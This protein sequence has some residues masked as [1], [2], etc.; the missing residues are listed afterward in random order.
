M[1]KFLEGLGISEVSAKNEDNMF[2]ID[3][4]EPEIE[5]KVEPDEKFK[6]SKKFKLNFQGQT[7]EFTA[8]E[9]L[10]L[11]EKGLEALSRKQVEQSSTPEEEKRTLDII[12]FMEDYPNVKVQDIPDEVWT[13]VKNGRTLNS[14]YALWENR[15]LKSQADA[16]QKSNEVS[17]R[18]VGSRQ[19]L[20]EEYD[21][22]L[23]AFL[24]K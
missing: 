6:S 23:S 11:A 7:A 18:S 14:A 13:A 19:G 21:E 4:I 5:P 8:E 20:N 15:Q 24:G 22:F 9:L 3:A 16:V 10:K 12:A 17:E 1:D 2:N